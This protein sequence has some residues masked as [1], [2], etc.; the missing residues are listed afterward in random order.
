MADVTVCLIEKLREEVPSSIHFDVGYYEKRNN[1]YWLVTAEDLDGMY[2]YIKDDVPLWC[3]AETK[4][5]KKKGKR[6]NGG[7]TSKLRKM[8]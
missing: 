2:A 5:D 8:M 3:D 7:T 6:R 1:K 4:R